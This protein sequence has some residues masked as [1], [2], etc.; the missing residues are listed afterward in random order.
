MVGSGT[1]GKSGIWLRVGGG[2]YIQ[3]GLCRA[4]LII[5]VAPFVS[6]EPEAPTIDWQEVREKKGGAPVDFVKWMVREMTRNAGTQ[7]ERKADDTKATARAGGAAGFR[8][9]AGAERPHP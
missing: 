5:F 8:L 3:L 7:K 6:L 2:L 9:G 1:S 4:N